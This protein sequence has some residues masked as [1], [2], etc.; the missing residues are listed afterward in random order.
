MI[1]QKALG[2][3]PAVVDIGGCVGGGGGGGGGR[4]GALASTAGVLGAGS[5][6][7]L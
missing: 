7:W 2:K 4:Y 5:T 3:L 1:K 6:Y